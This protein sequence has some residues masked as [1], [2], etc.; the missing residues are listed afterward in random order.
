[1]F[2]EHGPVY[3]Y[4]M[5]EEGKGYRWKVATRLD[6]SFR[7]LL[8]P[9]MKGLEWASD[10]GLLTSW[11]AGFTD[12]DG[13]IQISRSYNGVRMKLNLYNTDY[14][15]LVRL[16][17][18]MERLG[19]FPNGPYVTMAKGRSTPYGTYTKDLWNLPLQRTWEARKLLRDLPMR[20]RERQ[21]LRR[22]VA[23]IS[24]G[25][26]WKDIAPVV[27]E[28]REKVEKEVEDFAK[29]AEKEYRTRHLEASLVQ[30]KEGPRL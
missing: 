10:S 11:L 23:P 12:S 9:R 21:V 30:K 28:A 19:F 1:M 25:A 14:G 20:H 18:Q 7:F 3:Q 27:R 2:D 13:S 29:V 5:Y 22:I 15:P 17:G 4:P 8:T 26:R 6:N 16:E 24:K